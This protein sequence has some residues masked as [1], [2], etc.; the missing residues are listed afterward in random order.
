MNV[1]LSLLIYNP[2][3]AYTLILLCDVIIGR[4][5]KLCIKNIAI[6]YLLGTVNFSFQ[7][8]PN[9]WYGNLTYLFANFLI[10]FVI[11]PIWLHWAYEM[12]STSIVRHRPFIISITINCIFIMVITS[13]YHFLFNGNVL[14]R[15]NN[16]FTEFVINFTIFPVQIL[17]Y[18]I[19]KKRGSLYEERC[20]RDCEGFNC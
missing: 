15:N 8:I 11:C 12:M 1:P 18:K 19:I 16:I 17:L 7:Q 2:L 20:K 9:I 3:E 4:H 13:F 6:M 10:M 14:F 5:T